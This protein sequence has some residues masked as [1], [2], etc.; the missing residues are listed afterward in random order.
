M[1]TEQLE[2]LRLLTNA[3][4]DSRAPFACLL[5]GQPTLRRRLRLGSFAALDQRIGL[6]Y[7]ILRKQSGGGFAEID[8]QQELERNDEVVIRLQAGEPGY[9]YI[10]QRDAQNRWRMVRIGWSTGTATTAVL[11]ELLT[12]AGVHVRALPTIGLVAEV[13]RD[14][15]GGESDIIIVALWADLDA[16]PLDDRTSDP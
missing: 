4:M 7:N 13:G 11:A 9:L 5:L 8:P 6:R 1:S 14:A 3:E 12:E 10:L 16:L 2:S 15:G